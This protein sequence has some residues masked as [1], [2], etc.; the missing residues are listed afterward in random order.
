MANPLKATLES[1]AESP[2]TRLTPADFIE[3]ARAEHLLGLSTGNGGVLEKTIQR[4]DNLKLY[5]VP[6]WQ[7]VLIESTNNRMKVRRIVPFSQFRFT[8]EFN[9]ELEK[10][11]E[12]QRA[13]SKRADEQA[14]LDRMKASAK[15][16]DTIVL[17]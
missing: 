10:F 6:S 17:T 15:I 9:P 8:E 14:K 13:M 7:A 11:R 4:R 5:L 3:L 1:N 2:A 16:D 12:E